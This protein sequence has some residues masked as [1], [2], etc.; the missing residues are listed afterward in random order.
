MIPP[1]FEAGR[2]DLWSD[3][4]L[5]AAGA[6]LRRRLRADFSLSGPDS[7]TIDID[8]SFRNHDIERAPHDPR[9]I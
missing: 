9:R 4:G 5:G 6:A 8:P 2:G 7:I 1:G 3:A